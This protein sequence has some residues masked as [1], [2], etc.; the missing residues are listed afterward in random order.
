MLFDTYCVSQ[1]RT[2]KTILFSEDFMDDGSR[3]K[4]TI[5]ID[6]EEVFV[7]QINS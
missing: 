3:I 2:G 4:L 1:E 7:C 6:E 5:F